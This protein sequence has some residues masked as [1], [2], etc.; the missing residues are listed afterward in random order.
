MSAPSVL[1][2]LGVGGERSRRARE[3]L[4]RASAELVLALRRVVPFLTRKR[5]AVIAAPPRTSLFA[6]LPQ[7]IPDIAFRAPLVAGPTHT[8][9][10]LCIDSVGLSRIL[11]GVLGGGDMPAPP[12]DAGALSSAQTALATRAAASILRAFADAL[13]GSLGLAVEARAGGP[14]ASDSGACAVLSFAIAGGGVIALA[15]PV[16][17]LSDGEGVAENGDVRIAAAMVDVEVDVVAEL[18]KMRMP[19]ETLAALAV[20]DVL[21]LPLPL[22][23]RARVCAG[24]AVLFRGRPT[25]IGLAIGIAIERHAT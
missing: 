8:G 23:E 7:A 10:V 19:L 2:K 24:G 21:P 13:R 12:L 25:A 17:V 16:S 11:D 5:I 6:E 15:L 20:G 9:G 14:A 22:E 4:G 18:G 3:Q 1:A